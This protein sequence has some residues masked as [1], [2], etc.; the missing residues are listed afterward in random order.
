MMS[1]PHND[2]QNFTIFIVSI[3]FLLTNNLAFAADSPSATDSVNKCIGLAHEGKYRQAVEA[4]FRAIELDPKL[5]PAYIN[6]G[7]AYG[8][9]GEDQKATADLKTAAR[10]GDKKAQ[11]FLKSTGISW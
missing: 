4:C 9:L 2:G 3:F 7:V 8:S 11:D 5:V 1:H 10:S 6:R